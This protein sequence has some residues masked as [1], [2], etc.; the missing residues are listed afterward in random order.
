[1]KRIFINGKFLCQKITGVQRFAIEITKKMDELIDETVEFFIVLPSKE[2]VVSDINYKHINKIYLK[3][4]PNYY[5]EQV[6]LAKYCKK[7]HP[8]DLVN[9]CNIAPV[10][11]PGSCVIH[12][13]AWIDAK[14]GFSFKFRFVYKLITR[15]NIK[16]YKNIFTVSNTMKTRLKNY[17]K[18]NDVSV[19]YNSADHIKGLVETKP[20][21]ELPTNFYFSLGSINPNKNFK[22]I[23]RLASENPNLVFVISGKK[24]K[25]FANEKKLNIPNV[26]Y[27]GYLDDKELV[28][29]YKHCSGFLF[30]SNYEGFGI[31]PLEAMACNCQNIICNDIPVLRELFEKYVVFVDFNSIQDLS[32]LNNKSNNNNYTE[33]LEKYNWERSAKIIFDK[34]VIKNELDK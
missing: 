4:K 25:A 26:I 28:Y 30:P 12:D 17:Y 18:I 6:T 8:D 1:M 32:F 20:K 13:L 7:N 3:G 31:P 21:H 15:L 2:Y 9:L 22:S 19:V 34:I 11:Y 33:I 23:V 10:L 16:K 29:M 27:T 5:W 24:H 14:K